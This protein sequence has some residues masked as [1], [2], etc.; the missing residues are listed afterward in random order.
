MLGEGKFGKVFL[1]KR[2]IDGKEWAVK[3]IPKSNLKE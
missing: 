3:E 2:N 1:V